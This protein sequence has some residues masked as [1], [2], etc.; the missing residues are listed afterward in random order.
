MSILSAIKQQNSSIDD[1][2]KLPQAMIMQMAQQPE[3]QAEA[4]PAEQAAPQFKKGGKMKYKEGSKMDN[5]F[6]PKYK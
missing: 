6:K 3:P 4:M 1:L 5:K 2:A